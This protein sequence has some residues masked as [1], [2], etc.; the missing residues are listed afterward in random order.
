[1]SNLYYILGVLVVFALSGIRVIKE[2]ERAVIFFL[3]KQT[4]VR[5]PGLIY[6]IPILE[7]MVKVS[8]R[9]VTMAFLRKKLLQKTMFQLILRL[10]RIITLLTPKKRS[11]P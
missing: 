6:L 2:Y 1:M 9:T 10:L 11:L 7:K 8:F 5:G 3:G 4:D